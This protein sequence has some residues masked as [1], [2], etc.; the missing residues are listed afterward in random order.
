MYKNLVALDKIKHK[1][2]KLSSIDS[3]SFANEMTHIPV[4]VNEVIM[5][6]SVFPIVFSADEDTSLI[7]LVSLGNGNL[8]VNEEGKW[9][10]G[11]IPSFLRKY[12]F[13]FANSAENTEK[14]VV[15]IDEESSVFSRSK[16]K[17]LFKKSGE[18]SDVLK[19]A[20]EIL[21]SF[22]KQMHI[23][24]NVSKIILQSGILE[25]GSIAIGK[26]DDRKVLVN[27]FKVVNRE[28]LY[29]LSDD[30][31]ADWVRKGIIT[32]IE[33]HIKSLDTI[34]FLFNLEHQRQN[35]GA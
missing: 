22:E 9:M 10:S 23:T 16:G 18:E 8:G 25:D 7:S 12:P 6:G 24:K 1:T 13:A 31:L 11:Y 27:G 5:V 4:T 19:N 30:I 20:V 17:Q 29:A 15:L 14:K 34:Q 3:M 33:A 35:Q 21:L 26:G 28:K 32:L 2:L